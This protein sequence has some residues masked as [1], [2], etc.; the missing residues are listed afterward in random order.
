MHAFD[1][2]MFDIGGWFV[3]RL[4][5]F[6]VAEDTVRLQYQT[7]QQVPCSCPPM[8]IHGACLPRHQ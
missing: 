2:M 1:S 4:A 8:L 6:A 5:G 7:M 3:G